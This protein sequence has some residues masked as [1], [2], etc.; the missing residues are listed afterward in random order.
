M[1]RASLV[2]K[3]IQNDVYN[4]ILN[5]V[6]V[7]SSL[8]PHQKERYIQAIEKFISLY[9]DKDIEVYST[10]GRS[11]VCGNHTDHQHGEV[12]AAAI[13][14]DIIAIVA[15]HDSHIKI[16]SDDY[17]IHA[18][19]I[20]DLK[21]KE[22]ELETSEGLIRGVCARYLELGYKIGGFEAYMTSEVLQGSGLSSS[23]A[24]EV[25]VGTVLSGLYNQMSIDP[26]T[27]AQV[28]Q[29]SENVYFGKPCGLMDQCA[30]SVGSL[31]HIDFKDNNHP[32]VEKVDVDFS[33]FEHS[34][35]IV[36]VH[37]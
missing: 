29:Y 7:D 19:E 28:G 17:D 33:Q 26:V 13:N 31:I 32:I 10:P 4:K 27:I 14:L 23:A 8:I 6:Y 3:D 30:C 2:I 15:Y 37:A 5:D 21:K 20:D 35:C 9:G 25:I 36:D 11:E 12:L 34:L 22:E 18:I 16:L 1:K 24:F